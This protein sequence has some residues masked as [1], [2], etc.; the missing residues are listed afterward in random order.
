MLCT[1]GP[2]N[3]K[4]R[5]D[6]ECSVNDPRLRLLRPKPYACLHKKEK[7]VTYHCPLMKSWVA[8]R[9][10][11]FVHMPCA[12]NHMNAL[13][14]RVDR[15][16][17]PYR[18]AIMEQLL[19]PLALQLAKGVGRHPPIP[20][21]DVYKNY[22][23]K[24]R[25]RYSRAEQNLKRQGGLVTKRQGR[26]TGFVKMEG[27]KFSDHKRN[28]DCRLIQ[29]RSFEYTLRFA[30]AIKRAEH[31]LYR[32]ADI[33]GFP[34]T[35][36]I[37]KGLNPTA[38]GRLLR[39]KYDA[40]PGCKM[41]ELDASRFD[42]S[43]VIPLLLNTEHPVWNYACLDPEISNLLKVQLI[44][45]GQLRAKD[46]LQSYVVKGGRMSGDANTAAGN[47]IVMSCLLAAFGKYLG[48]KFDFLL[49]GDDSVFFYQMDRGVTED[50]VQS[51]FSPLA[52]DMKIEGRPQAFTDINFC[53]SKPVWLESGWT[54]VR[55]P[56]KVLS[57]VGVSHKL[58]VPHARAKYIR[59]V[60]LGE[61]SLSRGCPVVQ[62][63]LLRVIKVCEEQMT[64][65]QKRRGMLHK[66]VLDDN[67]RLK[68]FVPGDWT[69]VKILPITP[70]SRETFARAWGIPVN[71][72][73]R[74]EDIAGRWK[75]SLAQTV[76]GT[77]INPRTWV[78]SG[79]R[80]ERW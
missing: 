61:L 39:Q 54:M 67:Y 43:M 79:E 25:L 8:R 29:F 53:Q 3:K 35:R 66:G 75:F 51:F 15:C 32:A 31:A 70:K 58:T 71:D 45:R 49:D 23:A 78:F 36:F 19:L 41:L 21:F 14:L 34:S 40:M 60:A 59:T 80:P 28:P 24:K 17:P 47:C 30:A 52:M 11:W 13:L 16:L 46:F 64:A 42:S 9:D 10:D 4:H 69:Q 63:F 1:G 20:Y 2:G 73:Y 38:R 50:E 5:S 55:D 72:Q 62:P 12:C 76:R 6:C 37:A 44:N 57:K 33:P 48:C 22:G 27:I 56:F 68:E 26:L 18:P 7:Y 77:G 74:L 65:G